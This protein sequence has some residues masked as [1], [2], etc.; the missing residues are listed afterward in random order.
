MK[1]KSMKL[2]RMSLV[3]MI[4]GIVFSLPTRAFADGKIPFADTHDLFDIY[5]SSWFS[6]GE[7]GDSIKFSNLKSS[8]KKVVTVSTRKDGGLYLI[9]FNIKKVGKA[10]VSFKAKCNGHTYSYKSKVR[11]C[12]YK[13]P[14]K[15][16]NIGKKSIASNFNKFTFYN[17]KGKKLSGNLKLTLKKGWEFERAY[18]YSSTSSYYKDYAKIP[19]S[20][21]LKKKQTMAIVVRNKKH[22]Y[23]QTVHVSIS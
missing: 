23:Q 19:S 5:D 1:K 18:I 21:S 7:K 17:Y 20:V 3:L 13:N 22:D 9:G 4:L 2:L 8:N 15:T 14:I 12:K 16:L 11:V 10:T 6:F